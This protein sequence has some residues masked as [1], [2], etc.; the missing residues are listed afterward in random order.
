MKNRIHSQWWVHAVV[1]AMLLFG[2]SPVPGGAAMRLQAADGVKAGSG[3][4]TARAV[5]F[6]GKVESVDAAG[7]TV[8]LAG[9]SHA[10]QLNCRATSKIMRDGHEASL[11]DVHRGDAV[12]GQYRPGDGGSLEVVTLRVGAKAAASGAAK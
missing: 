7:G 6:H 1:A 4:G 3:S 11:A 9:K 2:I 12:S 5:P 10:R 8:T